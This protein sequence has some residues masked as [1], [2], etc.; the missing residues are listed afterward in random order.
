MSITGSSASSDPTSNCSGLPNPGVEVSIAGTTIVST[1]ISASAS[2]TSGAN[3]ATI[4][5]ETSSAG[6]AGPSQG[7]V[8]G[9]GISHG[10]IGGIVVGVLVVLL[11]LLVG[12]WAWVR[13][14]RKARR[15]TGVRALWDLGEVDA[16]MGQIQEDEPHSGRD[17]NDGVLDRIASEDKSQMYSAEPFDPLA[18]V[19]ASPIIQH[20]VHE[21]RAELMSGPHSASEESTGGAGVRSFDHILKQ[22]P[23][24]AHSRSSD[25]SRQAAATQAIPSQ[26]Q[27]QP[28]QPAQIEPLR[29]HSV[30]APVDI[31]SRRLQQMPAGSDSSSTITG[32]P[33]PR[34]QA[35][36]ETDDN[37][38]SGRLGDDRIIYFRHRD[39]T[40]GPARVVD[41]PP[42]YGDHL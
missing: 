24:G 37:D 4:P 35:S 25:R 13:W 16:P 11:L 28:P 20:G 1:G 3:G 30:A 27:P 2:A 41:L 15:G 5:S 21:P 32:D 36:P 7:G 18:V 22:S 33:S 10:A 23:L 17:I 40:R 14:S 31:S 26:S 39:V 6:L 34:H 9:K 12:T 8:P 29:S 38:G 19:G 42:A